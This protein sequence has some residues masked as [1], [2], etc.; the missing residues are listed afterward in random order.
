MIRFGENTIGLERVVVEVMGSGVCM[1]PNVG[2]DS[3]VWLG[4]VVGMGYYVEKAFERYM[5]GLFVGQDSCMHFRL[6]GNPKRYKVW[7]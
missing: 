7:I 6:E 4:L 5:F 2:M 1:G 3:G